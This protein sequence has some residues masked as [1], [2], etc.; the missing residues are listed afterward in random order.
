VFNAIVD[1]AWRNGEPGIVFRDEINRKNP[2]PEIG[3]IEAT[4]P[5]G[6]VPLLPNEACNL[7]SINLAKMTKIVDGFNYVDWDRLS[8]VVHLAVRFLDNVI[9]ANQFPLPQIDEMVRGN[10]KIGLGVMGF[11]DLLI[12]LGIP[13]NSQGAVGCAEEIMSFIQA[14]ATEASKLLAEERGAYPNSQG[15]CIRNATL[16]SIAPTGTISMICGA[17]SG[18]EPLFAVAY[19]K[20]VMDGTEFIEVNPLFKTFAE[21]HGFYTEELMQ[22]I[23]ERGMV[24]GLNEVP[25]RAQKLFVTAQEISPEW[26]VRIQVAFQKYTD[27]AVSKTINFANSAS[28]KDIGWA[29]HLAYSLKCKGITIYRD[30]SRD[31]QVLTTGTKH[32]DDEVTCP[33][34]GSELIHEAGCVCCKICGYSKCLL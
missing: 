20:T 4:N 27:N 19:T 9:D 31:E 22:T 5:C 24:T 34:C 25:E 16:T 15:E 10:R 28:R 6:E 17:S 11:A 8:Y 13:Y 3:E 30:G 32:H 33:E 2:T 29:F 7:G 14:E 18:I 12:A 1:H 26:H 21:K 23:A